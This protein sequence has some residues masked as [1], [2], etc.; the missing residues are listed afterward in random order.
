MLDR[1]V[2]KSVCIIC[3]NCDD[4][5]E[6]RGGTDAMTG[7]RINRLSSKFIFALSL[8][9]LLTVLTGYFQPPQTDEGTGAHISFSFPLWRWF[10]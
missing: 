6:S 3:N 4:S 7:Q 10:Q 2:S 9:A 1:R 5:F 8:I